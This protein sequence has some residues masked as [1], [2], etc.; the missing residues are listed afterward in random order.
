LLIFGSNFKTSG[1]RKQRGGMSGENC[2]LIATCSISR[3]LVRRLPQYFTGQMS[4]HNLREHL[5]C[6]PLDKGVHAHMIREVHR[7]YQETL[8]ATGLW[9]FAQQNGITNFNTLL[10]NIFLTS[11]NIYQQSELWY[12]II[13]QWCLTKTFWNFVPCILLDTYQRFR[14]T[15]FL[16]VEIL[17]YQNERCHFPK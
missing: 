4:R 1:R 10:R 3:G 12:L 11:Y 7:R 17:L 14:W 5:R 8:T 9:H 15:C 13:S 2:G 6:R 16:Q